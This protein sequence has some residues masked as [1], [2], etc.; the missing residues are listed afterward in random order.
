[1]N[2]L[3]KK[4]LW[5]ITLIFIT[6]SLIFW[7]MRLSPGD[8]VERILGPEAKIQEINELRKQLGLDL[9]II[10]QY[11][12]YLSEII[13]FEFGKS[14][15][16][17]KDV[18][19]LIKQ[20]FFP[21]FIISLVA[22]TLSTILGSCIGLVTAIFKGKFLDTFLRV[23]SLLGISFPIF[24]LA[25]LLVLFFSIKL[26]LLPVS[27]WGELKHLVLP[28]LT[29]MIPLS[30]IISRVARNRF[31]DDKSEQWALVLK[32]K[33]LSNSQINL[34]IFKVTLPTILNVMAIQ[35]SV[36][37]A[38]TII[39]ETIFDI[40]GMGLLLFEAIQNR[41]YPLVQ[42]I[43][44]YISIIYILIYFVIDRINEKIDPRLEKSA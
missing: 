39:T 24:S 4:S 30:A 25:P 44:V 18:L 16:K 3:I 42:G 43:I 37:M 12:T 6:V 31:L 10:K 34:R 32:A 33:G 20:H 22:I 2:E 40:P 26:G 27:E 11:F 35:L 5:L 21:S 38:G 9:P 13:R 23:I 8:P 36:V 1:M 14:L 29:L 19:L 15:F 41:D 17:N 28:S 7:A